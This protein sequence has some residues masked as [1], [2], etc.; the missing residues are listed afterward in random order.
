MKK[1]FSKFWKSSK[2]PRKQRKYRHNAPLHLKRKFLST[3]LS[4]DLREKYGKRNVKIRVGDT[5]TVMAGQFKKKTGIVSRVDMKKIKI[6]VEGVEMIKRDG[7][8]V[9]YPITPSNLMITEL[10]LTDLKRTE[11][12]NRK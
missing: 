10:L 4:K 2:Q 8:K 12:L 7:S 6:Y 5:V 1:I 11:S 9:Q 3:T